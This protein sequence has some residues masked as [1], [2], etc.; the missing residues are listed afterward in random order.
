M[1]QA[2]SCIVRCPLS[3]RRFL[4][5]F[6]SM[7]GVLFERKWFVTDRRTKWSTG[8]ASVILCRFAQL[9]QLN[10]VIGRV[11]WRI[12]IQ[13]FVKW[14]L[15]CFWNF[16][17]REVGKFCRRLTIIQKPLGTFR[18]LPIFRL[19]S[20]NYWE[21]RKYFKTKIYTFQKFLSALRLNAQCTKVN[22]TD[23]SNERMIIFAD[24]PLWKISI[25]VL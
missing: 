3:W 15:W 2:P 4:C 17:R 13:N 11:T 8:G 14:C 23:I 18:K 22:E 10:A 12:Q 21:F 7:G 6:V 9:I 16:G 20:D 24:F 25:L 1:T 19:C 5:N